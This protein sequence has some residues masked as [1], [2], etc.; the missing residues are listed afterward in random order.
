M[1]P[2][3]DL[4]WTPALRLR[5]L[6]RGQQLSPVEL[7]EAVLGQVDRVDPS[8]HAFVTLE[9]GD[10]LLAAA[11]AAEQA[12]GRGEE[13][14][15]LHGLPIAIKDLEPTSGL[16]TTFG[17]K[18]FEDN[19]PA[20]DGAVTG[21]VRAAGGIVLGKTNTPHWGHRDMCDNLVG[22][23]ARNPW[24]L[25]RTPGGS[26]GGAAAATACGM[27]PVHHGSD[28]A[29]SIRIP[30]ALC[31]VY[32]LKPSFGRVP[33]W[34]NSDVWAA[35]SHNGP[36][37]RTVRDAALLLSAIAG[38]DPRDPTS[39]DAPPRDYVALCD[40]DLSGLRVAWSVDFGY[41]RVD[42]EVR[43]VTEAA[44][45][46]F[47]EL[48]CAVEAVVPGWDDPAPAARTLWH[49]SMAYRYGHHYRER[50]DWF[51][52]SLAGMIEAGFRLSGMDVGGA[53]IARTAFYERARAFMERYDLLLTPQMP[54]V[55]WSVDGH[56]T[57]EGYPARDIFERLPF[58]FPFNLTGWPAASLPCGFNS[59]GRPFALQSV[60]PWHR[61]D[62]CLGAS[63]AFEAL[64]P[65]ADRR[66]AVAS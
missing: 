32:G 43:S 19:V 51:E 26:R 27:G 11:R 34:P 31:G 45:R 21:R 14:G 49:A 5:E 53:M 25:D 17:S 61:D 30:A 2:V 57:I 36:I 62:L 24:R 20:F 23:A 48:G 47:E 58:T 10:R 9:D 64:Q 50:P 42:P 44:A 38:P 55:A 39:L 15:L 66:P 41:A 52:P 28:G 40:G 65:W 35:R 4:L 33:Y 22:P 18:F 1:P 3:S 46:R 54:C 63:A 29:G 16:R 60:A 59:E 12:V 7:L 13:L 56:P 37:A 6:V 8:V